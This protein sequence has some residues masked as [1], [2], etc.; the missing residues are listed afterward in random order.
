MK[1]N[2]WKRYYILSYIWVP[3]STCVAI[4]LFY[5]TGRCDFSN[6]FA[7]NPRKVFA[8]MLFPNYR[9]EIVSK[10]VGKPTEPCFEILFRAWRVFTGVTTPVLIENP[11]NAHVNRSTKRA[12]IMW[13]P[14]SL[15]ECFFF[16]STLIVSYVHRMQ[17][18][19]WVLIRKWYENVE[20]T[21]THIFNFINLSDFNL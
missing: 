9:T 12:Y 13:R 5:V 17:F 14:H 21:L 19:M 6:M 8:S 2:G 10:S 20:V 18:V 1:L 4:E 16:I 15:G 11:I 7:T 3:T